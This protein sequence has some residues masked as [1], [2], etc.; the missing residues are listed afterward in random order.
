MAGRPAAASRS[1][2][3]GA[4]PGRTRCQRHPSRSEYWYAPSR[5]DTNEAVVSMERTPRCGRRGAAGGECGPHCRRFEQVSNSDSPVLVQ[6]TFP[7]ARAASPPLH[8]T[9][10]AN[11]QVL[12]E[13]SA[14]RP[15]HQRHLARDRKL[16]DL[17]ASLRKSI[18]GFRLP[19]GGTDMSGRIARWRIRQRPRTRSQE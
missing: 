13:I 11:M 8:R 19:G 12:R 5:P 15:I 1:G 7:P 6:I 9:S 4:A 10:R 17:S 14:H 3:R 16:A 18:T 2:R